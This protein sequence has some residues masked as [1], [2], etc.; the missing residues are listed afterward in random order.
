MHRIWKKVVSLS[1]KIGNQAADAVS[2]K[3]NP[4]RVRSCSCSCNPPLT[5]P[6]SITPLSMTRE[7]MTD[8][9]KPEDLPN[10]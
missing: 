7:G 8:W 5:K 1:P 3:G 10:K 6:V 2:T 4:V 9:G